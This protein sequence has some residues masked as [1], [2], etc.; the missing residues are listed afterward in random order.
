MKRILVAAVLLAAPS[1][2]FAQGTPPDPAVQALVNDWQAAQTA[3]QHVVQSM[4]GVIQ[5]LEMSKQRIKTLE[6]ELA[7]TKE[8]KKP[9]QAPAKK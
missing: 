6:A 7:K 5:S 3:Q 8:P 1:F 2:A 9:T 4:Q